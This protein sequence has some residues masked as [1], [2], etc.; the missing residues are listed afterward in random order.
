M[1]AFAKNCKSSRKEEKKKLPLKG[2]SLPN[3]PGGAL[4]DP[5]ADDAFRTALKQ[6]LHPSIEL[7]E[8]DSDINDA[9][10]ARTLVEALL[11]IAK[12]PLAA[13]NGSD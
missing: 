13:G 7:I 9:V 8:I 1:D 2:F 12:T 5:P 3:R 6:D 10:F 11:R 4:Y